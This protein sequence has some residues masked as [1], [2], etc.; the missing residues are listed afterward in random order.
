MLCSHNCK[1]LLLAW[2]CERAHAGMPLG[3]RPALCPALD[4]CSAGRRNARRPGPCCTGESLSRTIGNN[5]GPAASS[6]TMG[7]MPLSPH[8]M[9]AT[10]AIRALHPIQEESARST[11]SKKKKRGGG[12]RAK[13]MKFYCFSP[14]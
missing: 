13:R 14:N 7:P 8:A 11:Q 4:V 6:C 9:P 10:P 12:T 2:R 3:L 5:A 1:H